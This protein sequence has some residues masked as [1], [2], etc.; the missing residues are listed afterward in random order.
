VPTGGFELRIVEPDGTELVERFS[1][2]SDLEKR[3]NAVI[4][5][6]T[7]NGWSGPHGWNL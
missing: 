7:S 4:N 1:D 5:E 2:S 3:Q 6:V